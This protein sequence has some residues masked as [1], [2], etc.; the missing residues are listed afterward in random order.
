MTLP[1]GMAAGLA[2]GAAGLAGNVVSSI[3]SRQSQARQ[4][5][6]TQMM[7]STAH[8]REVAD[9][10]AAGLNP[11]LSANSG[12]STP[13]SAGMEIPNFGSTM[14]GAV[15][16]ALQ[17]RDIEIRKQLA[18]FQKNQYVVE[19]QK[20]QEQMRLLGVQIESEISNARTKKAEADIKTVI[21]DFIKKHPDL[22]NW[23]NTLGPIL[24]PL[25]N[26][27]GQLAK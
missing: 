11:I 5:A 24:Q 14:Q 10:R 20:M 19:Q 17:S 1:V 15:S 8:Q 16:T 23:I 13:S 9:L 22:T 26:L 4:N 7:S 18:Q 3:M 21:A 6:F 2:T 25:T 27:T 12:A